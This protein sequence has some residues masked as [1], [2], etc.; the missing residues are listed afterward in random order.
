MKYVVFSMADEEF[1]I[2]VDRVKEI[3]K[4]PHISPWPESPDFIE[5]VITLRKH[6][7]AVMDLQKR[8]NIHA[9]KVSRTRHIIVASSNGM[10]MGLLVN[11]VREI[12]DLYP[13]QIDETNRIL[14]QFLDDSAV[15]GVAHVGE[16]VILILQVSNILNPE[17]R[18]ELTEV[19][20]S[21]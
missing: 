5:G 14:N 10:I 3:L 16:R 12:I 9:D 4:V 8:F 1:G 21:E 17:V 18:S 13:K 19:T 15:T 6:S 7:I 20:K 11:G 2:S